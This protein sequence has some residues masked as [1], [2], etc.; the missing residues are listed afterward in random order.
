M[1]ICG[2]HKH[3]I[4]FNAVPQLCSITFHKIFKGNLAVALGKGKIALLRLYGHMDAGCILKCIC[5]KTQSHLSS[6]ESQQS[7]MVMNVPSPT[8]GWTYTL[9]RVAD[10]KIVLA[11]F[12][13]WKQFPILGCFMWEVSKSHWWIPHDWSLM[14]LC[15]IIRSTFKTKCP[16]NATANIQMAS[17]LRRN[18][19]NTAGTPTS[20]IRHGSPTATGWG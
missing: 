3:D 10:F 17:S 5:H 8:N 13:W 12:F 6:R 2:R 1:K 7:L 19:K 4:N 15:Y 16:L 20:L 14:H 11:P 18:Q 9:M